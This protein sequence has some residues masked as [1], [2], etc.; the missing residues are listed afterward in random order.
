M[1]QA[2]G[3]LSQVVS[4]REASFKT[5]PTSIKSKKIYF[6]TEALKFTQSFAESAIIRGGVRHPTQSSRDKTDV[7]GDIDSELNANTLLFFAALG[8]IETV[9]TGGTMGSALASPSAV[10][11]SATR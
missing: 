3:A 4:Q 2:Q 1:P 9:M 7:G 11:D 6:T 8:S 10:I 5:L